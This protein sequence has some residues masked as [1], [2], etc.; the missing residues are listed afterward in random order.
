MNARICFA[1]TQIIASMTGRSLTQGDPVDLSN[2]SNVPVRVEERTALMTV[3]VVKSD[4]STRVGLT[5][6]DG[7]AVD[8]GQIVR[9]STGLVETLTVR[10]PASG[11][12]RIELVGEG[13]AY[14]SL[15]L[16]PIDP[17]QRAVSAQSPTA[18]IGTSS[19]SYSFPARQVGLFA[20][21]LVVVVAAW[22]GWRRVRADRF[23]GV[24][25]A[26]NSPAKVLRLADLERRFRTVGILQRSIPLAAI[27]T[28]LGLQAGS[29]GRLF[30]KRGVLLIETS[31][32]TRRATPVV[33]GKAV[34]IGTVPPAELVF[35]RSSQEL[36]HVVFKPAFASEPVADQAEGP[37]EDIFQPAPTVH[38]SEPQDLDRDT[39]LSTT[40]AAVG[41]AGD[42]DAW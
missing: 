30:V 20:L 22:L 19:R 29:G 13:Q 5:M 24:V 6:P 10:E 9:T 12:W 35:A 34:E 27:A 14:V 36:P 4:A 23:V 17:S 8:P 39:I 21:F 16:K 3:T 7:R 18:A 41:M 1:F 40:P 32:A 15:V 42:D 33:Y 28:A 2:T 37:I 25:A 38:E 26:A 31:A 11:V